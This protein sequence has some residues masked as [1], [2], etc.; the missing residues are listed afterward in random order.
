M[1]KTGDSGEKL[2]VFSQLMLIIQTLK[3]HCLIILVLITIPKHIALPT[4]FHVVIEK[5]Y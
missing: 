4:V 5:E 1:C 2:F 3:L